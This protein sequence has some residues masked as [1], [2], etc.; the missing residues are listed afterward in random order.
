MLVCRPPW[1]AP[2]EY[3]LSSSCTAFPG[4]Y[5]THKHCL[6]TELLCLTIGISGG[7]SQKCLPGTP[8][9][10]ALLFIFTCEEN[11]DLPDFFGPL[12]FL[13]WNQASFSQGVKPCGCFEGSVYA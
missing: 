7:I 5:S 11:K 12:L 1:L 10:D 9:D 2:E 13:L 3:L 8:L 6:C 4:A